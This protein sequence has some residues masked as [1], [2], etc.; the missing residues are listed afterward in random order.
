MDR[1][2]GSALRRAQGE[3]SFM[4]QGE[5]SFTAQGERVCGLE[6]TEVEALDYIPIRSS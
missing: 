1:H 3:R 6:R 4:A 2:S 5:R